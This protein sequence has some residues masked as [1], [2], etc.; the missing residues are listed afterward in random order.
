MGPR[1]VDSLQRSHKTSYA[2]HEDQRSTI[3]KNA[4][5]KFEEA[6]QTFVRHLA[7]VMGI[8]IRKPRVK[9]LVKIYKEVAAFQKTLRPLKLKNGK[10]RYSKASLEDKAQRYSEKL[11][12][13]WAIYKEVAAFQ[14]T[15]RTLKLKNGKPRFSKASIETKAQRYSEKL[16]AKGAI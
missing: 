7:R 16:Y 11:Y 4:R 10:P 3:K 8:R 6:M 14:K 5:S 12:A 13:A 15:L 9:I 1:Y 2:D